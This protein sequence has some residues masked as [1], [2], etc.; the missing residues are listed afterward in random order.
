MFGI[1]DPQ[2]W[3][4]YLLCILSAIL[5]VAYGIVKWNSDD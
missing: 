4:A 2:I 1:P 3:L 5:C